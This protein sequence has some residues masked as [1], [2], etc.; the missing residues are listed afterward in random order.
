M[1]PSIC[2]IVGFTLLATWVSPVWAESKPPGPLLKIDWQ[3]QQAAQQLSSGQL[4]AA[5]GTE[6]TR[7]RL[8]HQG[9]GPRQFQLAVL[10]DPPITTDHVSYV[11]RGR[12]RYENVTGVGYLELL[13]YFGDSPYF[14]RTLATSGTLGQL[15][16]TSDWRD[17]ALPFFKNHE[18]PPQK[19]EINLHLPGS[20]IVELTDL[21][22]IAP[23]D[24]ALSGSPAN[25]WWSDR[26]GGYIGGI[27]GSVLGILL[28]AV[29]GPLVAKG[30][31]KRFAL[32]T[33]A[34]VGTLSVVSLLA[35]LV[36]ICLQQPY[37]VCYPL[38]LIG[39]LGSALGWGGFA[40]TVKRYREHE[41]RKMSALDAL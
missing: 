28:G 37:G 29:V 27:G 10:N 25:A 18:P 36:A 20:G 33:L 22:L 15:T 2:S 7:L 13:N 21:E 9:A 26:A 1:R 31:A 4:L 11:I 24:L 32:V 41:L 3:D 14:S 16:G 6:P 8:E 30:R 40:Q 5:E 19:L 12:V 34:V 23:A 39:G 17:F 35:G 38:L